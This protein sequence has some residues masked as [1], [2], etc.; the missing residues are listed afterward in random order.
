MLEWLLR[1]RELGTSEAARGKRCAFGRRKVLG[2]TWGLCSQGVAE[3]ALARGDQDSAAHWLYLLLCVALRQHQ[4]GAVIA[5]LP[6]FKLLSWF[7]DNYCGGS[8]E[9]HRFDV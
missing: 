4:H 2:V 7:C 1:T 6:C 8:D 5:V 9:N 3:A